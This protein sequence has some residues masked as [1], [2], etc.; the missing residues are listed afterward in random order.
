MYPL[1]AI[2]ARPFSLLEVVTANI[3]YQRLVVRTGLEEVIN[4]LTKVNWC[5]DPKL[6]DEYWSR[7]SRSF[8]K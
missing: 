8:S 4:I 7:F 6:E 3:R 5:P 1:P 2:S